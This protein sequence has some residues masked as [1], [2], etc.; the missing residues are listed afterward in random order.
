MKREIPPLERAYRILA[1]R[2][3]SEAELAAK[4]R[5][6]G[7]S[8]AD[9]ER[10]IAECRKHG[11]L[12][13]ELF[14]SDCAGALA[15]RGFGMAKIRHEL[16]RRGVGEYTETATEDLQESELERA[17][18]AARRKRRLLTRESDPRK[19]YEKVCRY[20]LSRG[21]SPGVTREAFRRSGEA[22]E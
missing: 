3:H 8:A 1:G 9:I 7:V 22:E 12:N 21:F 11:F 5:R 10:V 20:L 19:L 17:I 16:R 14:S 4:L 2:G 15:G 13:D 6:A 18:D